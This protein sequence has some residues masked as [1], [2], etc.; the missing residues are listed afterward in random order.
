MARQPKLRQKDGFWFSEAG[1]KPRRYGKVG[2]VAFEDAQRA[3]IADLAARPAAGNPALKPA[4]PEV[5]TI[6]L[7]TDFLK[8][9][10]EHRGERA[11]DHRHPHLT[12]W[13]IH[14]GPKR[15]ASSV[16]REDME[17]FLADLKG[18]GDAPDYQR[19]HFVSVS[20]MYTWA[21]KHER[22][23][24]VKPFAAVEPV[25][26]PNKVLSEHDLPT[27]DEVA[28][29]F[30]FADAEL[31]PVLVRFKGSKEAAA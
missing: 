17:G 27:P 25:R 16:K 3:F 21:V 20:A 31:D 30:E 15:K 28:R 23:P 7:M 2:M 22:V 13:S 8:R 4:L 24:P 12:R 6:E 19:K 1:G 14:V 18:Q 26:V 29:L 5:A 11:Y 9:V 10:K